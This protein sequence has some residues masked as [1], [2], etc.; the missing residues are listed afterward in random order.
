MP[1]MIQYGTLDHRVRYVE[2]TPKHKY[3]GYNTERYL[4]DKTP[5]RPN[6]CISKL[7][8]KRDFRINSE[9]FMTERIQRDWK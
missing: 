1:I 5:K 4:S 6:Q 8:K 2:N 3:C 9:D 7:T